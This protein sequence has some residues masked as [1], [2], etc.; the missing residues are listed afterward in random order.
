MRTLT[1]ERPQQSER[2]A[3]HDTRS[4]LGDALSGG[5]S[6]GLLAGWFAFLL[7]AMYLEPAPAPD[8]TAVMTWIGNVL[9]VVVI[10]TVYVAVAG[11]A[12]RRRWGLV[13]SLG[14]AGLLIADSIACPMTGHHHFGAWVVVQ[15]VGSVAL[16]GASIRALRQT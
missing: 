16:A 2:P 11:L 6:F 5:W 12:F 15:A 7:F 9:S 3:R 13:A 14:A 10:G 4:W 1:E 8:Q